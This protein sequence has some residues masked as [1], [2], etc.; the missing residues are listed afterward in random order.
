MH[1]GQPTGTLTGNPALDAGLT[2]DGAYDLNGAV[3]NPDL[4][5]INRKPDW[6]WAMTSEDEWYKA[7]YYDPNK[8]GPNQPGY[9]DY[10]TKSN[11][12]PGR[13]MTEATNPGNNANCFGIGIPFP[14]DSPY[15]TTLAG[16]FELSESPYNTF[17]QGGNAWEWNE[18]IMSDSS[19]SS[20]AMRGSSFWYAINVMRGTCRYY[21]PVLRT[22]EDSN[23]GFRV[24]SVPEPGSIAGYAFS[25]PWQTPARLSLVKLLTGVAD[26]DGHSLAVSGTGPASAEGGMATLQAGSILYTPPAGFSGT[27]SFPVTITDVL[28]AE[29]AGTVAVTVGPAPGAGGGSTT[30]LSQITIRP[31]GRKDI[32][33]QGIPGRTYRI[34]RSTDMTIWTTLATVI[35]S[36]TGQ[37]AFTDE[38]PPPGSAFYR[39]A[40]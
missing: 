6:K 40:Y 39:I 7:A 13:D 18:A 32:G 25:T 12:K 16:E 22:Y 29:V 11:A 37:V 26:P 33:F 1:N 38:S 19:G 24:A 36:P 9:W 21:S 31:D 2:E 34:E 17:D 30:N 35:S 20:G 3:S 8:L 15:Y 4:M 28:G 23:V 5:A 10:P 27:D 14:I